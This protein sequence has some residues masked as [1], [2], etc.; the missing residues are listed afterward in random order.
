MFY[1][2]LFI[3]I[4]HLLFE[5]SCMYVCYLLFPINNNNNNIKLP[6][7]RIV[8]TYERHHYGE[9]GL[10]LV[11]I[12][13][14]VY[15]MYVVVSTER[16][17]TSTP[18]MLFNPRSHQHF[19]I[20]TSLTNLSVSVNSVKCCALSNSESVQSQ[21]Q[22]Q[23]S[24]DQCLQSHRIDQRKHSIQLQ[25]I[26]YVSMVIFCE[27]RC[28]GLLGDQAKYM[29]ILWHVYVLF[30]LS[31]PQVGIAQNTCSLAVVLFGVADKYWPRLL[32]KSDSC[33]ISKLSF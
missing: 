18:V 25:F 15:L 13:C 23:P 30:F 26:D 7:E 20:S 17:Q 3:D 12:C 19:G 6:S 16:G 31:P 8:S 33:L 22:R 24:D 28:S 11:V 27:N 2:F 1:F 21:C 9:E 14:T 4:I 32:L 5:V 10:E 29:I